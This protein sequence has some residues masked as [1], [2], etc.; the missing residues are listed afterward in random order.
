MEPGMI[1]HFNMSP[2]NN[3]KRPHLKISNYLGLVS[4]FLRPRLGNLLDLGNFIILLNWLVLKLFKIV[5]KPQGIFQC[6]LLHVVTRS[7]GGMRYE[8]SFPKI[9][10]FQKE[11]QL[12]NLLKDSSFVIFL[13]WLVLKHLMS[14]W[15]RWGI[16]GCDFWQF[17]TRSIAE[18]TKFTNLHSSPKEMQLRKSCVSFGE[19]C[20]QNVGGL[21]PQPGFGWGPFEVW[22]GTPIG[23]LRKP[24]LGPRS[25][26]YWVLARKQSV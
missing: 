23:L 24:V 14:V 25:P 5:R 22:C 11:R 19:E 18:M 4:N 17:G 20:T 13:Q 15:Y 2:L 9:Q 1:F 12:P 7:P 8:P 3:G 6:G 26:T 16:L 10:S 21:G